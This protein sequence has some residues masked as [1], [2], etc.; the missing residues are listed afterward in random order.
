MIRHFGCVLIYGTLS[1]DGSGEMQ[2]SKRTGLLH[3]P[4]ILLMEGSTPQAGRTAESFSQKIWI[5]F[6]TMIN[7]SYINMFDSQQNK[8]NQTFI[9]FY[10]TLSQSYAR[11]LKQM[12]ADQPGCVHFF[13]A[14]AKESWQE[15]NECSALFDLLTIK[16]ID[17]MMDLC[18]SE[19]KPVDFSRK[20]ICSKKHAI[21][22]SRKLSPR[23]AQ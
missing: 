8:H 19:I 16:H 17:C 15:R 6:R 12:N 21:K 10:R 18:S 22:K 9:S 20:P 1:A 5:T 3:R 14:G 13:D 4:E 2:S 23:T 11:L 7:P